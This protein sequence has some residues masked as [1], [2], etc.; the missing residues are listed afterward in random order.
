MKKSTHYVLLV[1]RITAGALILIAVIELSATWSFGVT[2]AANMV[3]F[4]L[5]YALFWS[6]PYRY[7]PPNSKNTHE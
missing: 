3:A 4:A 2:V 1:G 5:V 6:P 7:S